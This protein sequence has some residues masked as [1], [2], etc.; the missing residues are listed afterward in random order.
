MSC[1]LATLAACFSLSGIYVDSGVAYQDAGQYRERWEVITYDF[2]GGIKGT[3]GMWV[4]DNEP[5]N[6][7]GRLALGFQAE[8]QLSRSKVVLSLEANHISSMATGRDRG[9]NGITFGA[10]YF[11]FARQ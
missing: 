5:Q 4:P 3:S 1:T 9:V 8:L 7:Y 11:P 6:M 2:P 10:R